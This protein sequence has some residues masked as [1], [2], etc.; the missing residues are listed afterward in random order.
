MDVV[1]YVLPI[2]PIWNVQASLRHRI[3]LIS[4]F[5]LGGLTIVISTLRFIVLWQLANTDDVTYI[6]GS[7]TIVTSIEFS[8]AMITANMPGMYA[9]W[10][11]KI[12]KKEQSGQQFDHHDSSAA[13]VKRRSMGATGSGSRTTNLSTHPHDGYIKTGSQEELYP[14]SRLDGSVDKGDVRAD[15]KSSVNIDDREVTHGADL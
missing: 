4:I 7:V 1:I 3:G 9:F 8:V 6:F 10:R 12:S 11:T 2:F 15:T 14:M 5:T 13:R